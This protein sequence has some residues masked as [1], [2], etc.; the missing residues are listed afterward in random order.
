MGKPLSLDP[1]GSG[2]APSEAR[3]EAVLERY[4]SYIAEI[5]A[6][7]APQKLGVEPAEIEQ[8]TTL[9][10]WRSLRNEREIRNYQ[11]YVYRIAATA[12][13]DAIREIK[14]RMESQLGADELVGISEH[15]ALPGS[16]AVSPERALEDKRLTAAIF[17]AL[18]HLAENRRRAV[19]LHLQGF[20]SQEI[21]EV[22]GWSE[23]KARNLTYRGLTDL[24]ELLKK[25]GVDGDQ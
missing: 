9:R 8:V 18:Q 15:A 22:C 23:P 10:L 24:R 12:A 3:I 4:R 21:A 5:V 1:F 11:S 17:E 2:A 16:R 7:L 13:L 20:T 25:A 14:Q 19:K 6:R